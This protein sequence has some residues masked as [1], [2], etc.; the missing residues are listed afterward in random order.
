MLNGGAASI[1]WI[2]LAIL[3]GL[4]VNVMRNGTVADVSWLGEGESKSSRNR[5]CDKSEDEGCKDFHIFAR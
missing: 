1:I 4:A 3:R 5:D 2:G